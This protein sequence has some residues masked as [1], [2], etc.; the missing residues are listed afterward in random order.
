MLFSLAL[1]SLICL[2]LTTAPAYTADNDISSP[3][4][5]RLSNKSKISQQ[6]I[7]QLIKL[8][9]KWINSKG[10]SGKRF[11]LRGAFLKCVNLDGADLRGALLQD[12]DMSH[13]SL[14]KANLGCI[15]LEKPQNA[16]ATTG[17]DAP[18]NTDLTHAKLCSADLSNADLTS[19][20][21]R[22]TNI[23][24]ADFT[25]SKLFNVLY[26]PKP[27]QPDFYSISRA[28]NLDTLRYDKTPNGLEGLRS[29]FRAHGYKKQDRELT[30][31]IRHSELTI[32]Y[33]EGHVFRY[34]FSYAFFEFPC[35]WGLE[36]SRC[37]YILS[38]QIALFWIIYSCALL[39]PFFQG[40]IHE[41]HYPNK[42]RGGQPSSTLGLLKKPWYFKIFRALQFSIL[43]AF[44]IGWHNLSISEWLSRIQLQNYRLEA[45]GWVR[46]TSG[47]QALLGIYLFGLWWATAFGGNPFDW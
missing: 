32:L 3:W 23:E 20:I 17:G 45:T 38:L 15:D 31:A 46:A 36:P 41:V 24:D 42:L 5:G 22:R 6:D 7:T 16:C 12:A 10:L 14:V 33:N 39:F 1:T 4:T 37:M 18:I 44:N 43:S 13:A 29:T 47:F 9:E 8:H 2:L 27:Y 35:K 25:D 28:N 40:S 30:Y 19:A 34:F 11:D 26:E 21:L